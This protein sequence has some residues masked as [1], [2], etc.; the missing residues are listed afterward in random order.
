MFAAGRT[1][2][3]GARAA[4]WAFC[5]GWVSVEHRIHTQRKGM[6]GDYIPRTLTVGLFS[7]SLVL[8]AKLL[9]EGS[10]EV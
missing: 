4:K 2:G 8:V 6:K 9:K 1:G 3:G 5:R 10:L 7:I